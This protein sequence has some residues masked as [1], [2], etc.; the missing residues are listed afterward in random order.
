[1]IKWNSDGADFVHDFGLGMECSFPEYR[2]GLTMESRNWGWCPRL[3]QGSSLP[4][5]QLYAKWRGMC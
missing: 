5:M 2:K 1:M 4:G 3:F